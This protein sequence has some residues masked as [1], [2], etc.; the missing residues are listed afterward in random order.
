M[1]IICSNGVVIR[2]RFF[3]ANSL[4][5]IGLS[6]VHSD[7][8]LHFTHATGLADPRKRGLKHHNLLVASS[9]DKTVSIWSLDALESV[10][11]QQA[12]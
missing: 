4:T 3:D 11:S 10:I 8:I 1:V 6:N 9:E 5:L 12:H 7:T 2:I